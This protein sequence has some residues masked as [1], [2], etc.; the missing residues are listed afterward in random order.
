MRGTCT[1][2]WLRNFTHVN[3]LLLTKFR[4]HYGRFIII[5]DIL[6]HSYY[7]FSIELNVPDRSLRFYYVMQ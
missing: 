6:I 7:I 2:K 1:N 5:K 4:L 3:I